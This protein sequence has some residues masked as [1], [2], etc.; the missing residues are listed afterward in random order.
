MTVKEKIYEIVSR[1]MKR[2]I[3]ELNDSTNLKKDLNADS[4]DTVEIIFELEENLVLCDL[5]LAHDSNLIHKDQKV[6][7]AVP[8]INKLVSR[9]VALTDKI[10]D[11]L[12]KGKII[13]IGKSLDKVW[14][15]KKM[16]SKKISN[17]KID[18]V[19]QNAKKNGA[20]GGKLLGAGGGGFF[21]FYV[22]P[23]KKN[24]LVNYLNNTGKIVKN[25][26]FDELGLQSW[27]IREDDS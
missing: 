19:Y 2:D 14:E 17:S 12:I 23:T 3:S 4:I 8:E 13:E 18:K 10:K 7:M 26:Q 22:S 16:F 5:N 27:K 9:N 15:L 20:I 25:F 1:R 24:E 6:Q 21:L 11:N